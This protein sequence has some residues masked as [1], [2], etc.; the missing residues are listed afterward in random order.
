MNNSGDNR[1]F[2]SELHEND[3]HTGSRESGSLDKFGLVSVVMPAYNSEKYIGDAISSVL[4]QT[5]PFFELIIVD[6][7]STDRT[8]EIVS[9]FSDE[10]IVLLT[11]EKN[12]GVAEARNT[13]LKKARGKW[14]A[15]IDS[16]DVWLPERLEKLLL[17]LNER[18]EEKHFIADD[19]VICFDSD[20]GLK[21]WGSSFKLYYNSIRFNG[22]VLYFS[23]S[24]YIRHNELPIHPIFPIEAIRNDNLLFRQEYVPVEDFLFYCE[25][26]KAGYNLILTREPYYLYR[27]TP[28]SITSKKPKKTS[29]DAIL[30]LLSK[31]SLNKEESD[32]LRRLLNKTKADFEYNTF[33]YHLKHKEFSEALRSF[34]K[35]PFLGFKLILRLPLSLWYR[36]RAKIFRGKI[37]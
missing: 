3:V 22:D 21:K 11:H 32:L 37:K 36:I 9:S 15:L 4:K 18:S 30:F 17:I 25:L 31:Y 2:S 27:L 28:G 12:R 35:N 24:D 29:I 23:F 7:G 5:Y 20:G 8:R 13:A 34:L 33:T 14:V 10:R 19:M 16:D 26:F 6:D 1:D